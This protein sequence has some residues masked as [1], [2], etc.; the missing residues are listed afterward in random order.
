MNLL[1]LLAKYAKKVLCND[2]L[3]V[4]LSVRPSVRLSHRSTVATA[5]GEF[6]A[7]GPADRRRR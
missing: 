5:S 2:M 7:V 3:S 6:A 1:T 4:R